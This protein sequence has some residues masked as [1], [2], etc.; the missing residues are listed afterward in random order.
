MFADEDGTEQKPFPCH[1]WFPSDFP[2]CV[3]EA[4]LEEKRVRDEERAVREVQAGNAA[5]L[6]I[7]ELLQR[8][9]TPGQD[10]LY[11]TAGIRLLAEAV[12]NCEYLMPKLLIVGVVTQAEEGK[13]AVFKGA[14]ELFL[15]LKHQTGSV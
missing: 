7:Q 1:A 9:N 12:G 14:E 13:G 4:N 8:I 3:N 2:D 15:Y 11:Y 5:A 10:I 6:S